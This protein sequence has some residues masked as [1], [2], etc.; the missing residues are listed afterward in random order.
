MDAL[1]R[2]ILRKKVALHYAA[3]TGSV[4]ETCKALGVPRSSFYR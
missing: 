2:S 4:V 3:R 1:D